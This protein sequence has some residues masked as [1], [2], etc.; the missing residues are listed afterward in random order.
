MI[1][2]IMTFL[3]MDSVMKH[4]K[5]DL[6]LAVYAQIHLNLYSTRKEV[7]KMRLESKIATREKLNFK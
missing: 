3:V 1:I 6:D 5:V 4:H 7:F 2:K